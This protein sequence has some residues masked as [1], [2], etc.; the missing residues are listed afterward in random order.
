EGIAQDMKYAIGYDLADPEEQTSWDTVESFISKAQ[1]MG[2]KD[3]MFFTNTE[4]EDGCRTL[5]RYFKDLTIYLVER[6]YI[7]KSLLKSNFRLNDEK[8]ED[9]LSQIHDHK[10]KRS[11]I[12]KARILSTAKP[13]GIFI[14]AAIFFV[15]AFIIKRY[16]IYY[17]LIS[18]MFF[19]LGIVLFLIA[20][21]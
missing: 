11:K 2:Y 8:V 21:E 5:K 13:S 15:L 4:F 10:L 9:M 19:V 6:D 20:K 3:I 1:E 7:I 12:K 17:I 14:Y 16:F 18:A